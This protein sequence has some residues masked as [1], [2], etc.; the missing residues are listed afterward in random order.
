MK[1][2]VKFVVL[3]ALA[4]SAGGLRAE[5]VSVL[6]W[7]VSDPMVEALDGT[8]LHVEEVFARNGESINAARVRVTQNNEDGES[9]YLDL[10]GFDGQKNGA[11]AVE[12]SMVENPHPLPGES[13]NWG[14]FGGPAMSPV[15][16]A[17][18]TEEYLFTME[19]GH[20]DEMNGNWLVMAASESR[21]G[22]YLLEKFVSTDDLIV[23]GH[24][25]WRPNAFNVP[26]PSSGMLILLGG[27]LV[28]LRRRRRGGRAARVM[29]RF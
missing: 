14:M 2:L 23:P 20:Y 24:L 28:A 11:K 3:F 4:A 1:T 18:M 29:N 12:I 8:S 13:I 10:L 21:T 16:I 15:D 17:W 6:Y 7:M 9:F 26:E 19:L 5:E 22:S 27:A 25:D